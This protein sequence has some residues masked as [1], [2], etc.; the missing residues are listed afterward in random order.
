MA[1]PE[2]LFR[3]VGLNTTP[4]LLPA[5]QP[6]EVTHREGREQMCHMG[7]KPGTS[8]KMDPG[9]HYKLL[10]GPGGRDQSLL[11]GRAVLPGPSPTVPPKAQAPLP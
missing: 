8:Q 9:I 6:L 7:S 11:S 10:Q 4:G 5:Q 3:G 2:Q 1:C